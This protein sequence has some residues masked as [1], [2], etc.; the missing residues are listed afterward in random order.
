MMII[1][2]VVDIVDLEVGIE[3]E[4]VVAGGEGRGKSR[5]R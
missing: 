1:V 2:I 5:N 4:V 3:E